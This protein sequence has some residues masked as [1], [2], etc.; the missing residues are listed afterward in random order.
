[1]P[2]TAD[3]FGLQRTWWYDG[4][5]DIIASTEAAVRYLTYLHD[6]F[7]DWLLSLAAYNA[8]EGRVRR[9]IARNRK[10]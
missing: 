2:Q 6:L 9:A 3:R 5:R 8:G 1:M 4:R 10:L 7:D